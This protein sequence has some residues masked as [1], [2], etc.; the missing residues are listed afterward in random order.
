[1]GPTT[2]GN[3]RSSFFMLKPAAPEGDF[4]HPNVSRVIKMSAAEQR[5]M[6]VVV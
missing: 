3:S 6:I 4:A 2:D 1:M 5:D